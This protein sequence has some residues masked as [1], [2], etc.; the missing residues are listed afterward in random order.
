MG[1]GNIYDK[2]PTYIELC[3]NPLTDA[4]Y[5]RRILIP[6]VNRELNV[7]PKL[8]IKDGGMR[9]RINNKYL[10]DWVKSEGI[11]AGAS[12]ASAKIP[13]FILDDNRL[14]I[15]CIRGIF[16]TDGSVYFDLRPVY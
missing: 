10:V 3:G 5:F 13:K 2:G 14:L 7:N 8:F 16:D 1:D 4:D 15:P 6:I 11:P 12:K 9:F